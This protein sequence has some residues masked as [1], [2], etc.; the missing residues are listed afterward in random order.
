LYNKPKAAVLTGGFMLT[1]PRGGG[2]GEEGGGEEEEEGG[3]EEE[4]EEGEAA[5]ANL[6]SPSVAIAFLPRVKA[7]RA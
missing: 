2:G 1:G 5:V 7:A 4:E 6:A 3:G